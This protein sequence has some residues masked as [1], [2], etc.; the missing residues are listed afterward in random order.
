MQVSKNDIDHIITSSPDVIERVLKVAHT[1]INGHMNR[2]KEE[3][4]QSNL[5][6]EKEESMKMM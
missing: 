5:A 2:R 4:G 1:K 6:K 3:V